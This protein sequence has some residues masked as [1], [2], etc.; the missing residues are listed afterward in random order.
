MCMTDIQS[1]TAGIR[2]EKRKKEEE[3]RKKPQG[4]SIMA[5]PIQS[6]P[7]NHGSLCYI[8]SD[9]AVYCSQMHQQF[10]DVHTSLVKILCQDMIVFQV[11][12]EHRDVYNGREQT[13]FYLLPDWMCCAD[14][15]EVFACF[16]VT[17]VNI[18]LVFRHNDCN[19]G[20]CF[21]VD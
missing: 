15:S 19:N 4:K 6:N 13:E 2:R 8:L 21:K 16:I 9:L 20:F 1:A 5:C 14:T 10:C 17:D 7:S 3:E 18:L 11:E 12:N